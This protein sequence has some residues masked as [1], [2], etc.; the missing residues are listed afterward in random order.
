M[1]RL[2]FLSQQ[3]LTIEQLKQ[4]EKDAIDF[5]EYANKREKEL[6][7]FEEEYEEAYIKTFKPSEK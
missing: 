1:Q 4:L 2:Y 3:Q 5:V 7:M 6:K